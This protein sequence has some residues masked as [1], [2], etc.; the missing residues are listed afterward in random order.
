MKGHFIKT[1]PLLLASAQ[2]LS[3]EPSPKD[4]LES[5]PRT[6]VI[7]QKLDT[8]QSGEISSEEFKLAPKL[9]NASE[10]QKSRLF[11][12]LDKNQDGELQP[13]ELKLNKRPKRHDWQMKG[14]VTFEQFI[15]L[16]HIQKLDPEKQRK[17]FQ[18][19]DKNGDQTLSREDRR[20]RPKSPAHRRHKGP[21]LFEQMD[22]NNDQKL[23]FTEYFEAPHIHKLGEDEAEDRFEALD[24]DK[25]GLLSSEE[26]PTRPK[27]GNK[28]RGK[29]S[30]SAPP[31][32]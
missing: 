28:K 30:N 24:K 4:N 1:A 31:L 3:A 10:E 8:D 17:L 22:L 32:F 25:D 14:P 13:K 5:G 2:V 16:S 9:A 27:K 23:S 21:P 26:L 19:L 18:R 20:P 15:K 7:F 11:R 6:E 29:D 12:R